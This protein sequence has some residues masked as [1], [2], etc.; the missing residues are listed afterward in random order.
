MADNHDLSEAEALERFVRGTLGQMRVC[1]PGV[2]EE[3]DPESQLAK[4]QP[5][6]QMKVNVREGAPEYRDLPPL[7][8]VPV[9]VPLV[10]TLGLALTLPIRPGD[11][12]LLLFS[13]RF[14][15]N[16]LM[17][18]GVQPPEAAGADW[19][20]SEPRM[21]SLSDGIFLPGV[22][23]QPRK[24]PDW[25]NEAIELRNRERDCFISLRADKDIVI[26]TVGK[27]FIRGAE[28]H[29]NDVEA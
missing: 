23:T 5:A 18:G 29:L 4:V 22:I 10:Q 15:D 1:L 8:K 27:V 14:L 19:L 11:E 21:H 6:I 16:F 2:V 9:V 24:L 26:Q 28:V 13:D 17:K 3:F 12:G 25:N 7:V 20:T